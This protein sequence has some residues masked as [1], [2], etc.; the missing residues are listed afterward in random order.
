MELKVD[1]YNINYEKAPE[2][3]AR[4]KSLNDYS[5]FVH[6]VKMGVQFG[7]TFDEAVEDAVMYCI[8][9]NIMKEFL[10]LHGSEVSNMLLSEWNMDEALEVTQ[11]EAFADGVEYGL[12]RGIEQGLERGIEQGLE[13]GVAQ[14]E[15][16]EREKNIRAL[17][18]KLSAED[19]AET[20]EVPLDYVLK[21]MN[22]E[23]AYTMQV[24]EPD[25][26]YVA[27]KKQ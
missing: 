24:R 20:L 8:R 16:A 18:R 1:I 10:E 17:R 3:I 19:I 23:A 25:V 27:V 2:I 12:E 7:K 9:N 26:E 4:S 21:V 5:L 14:G 6:T 11:E 15:T 22:H 13:R